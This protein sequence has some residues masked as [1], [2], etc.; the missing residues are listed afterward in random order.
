MTTESLSVTIEGELLTV[1]IGTVAAPAGSGGGSAAWGDITGTLS[2]QTDLSAALALKAPLASPTLTGTPAAPTAAGGTST[3]QIATTAFA[4]GEITTHA[5][6]T[7]PHGDRS[8][9]TSAVSTHAALTTGVH[10]LGGASQLNVGTTAGTVAAGDHAHAGVYQPIA[11][12]LTNTT[13]AFTT[14]QETKLSGIEAAAD[15]TDAGN[16]GTAID[17]ATAKTTPVDADTVPLIDSAAGNVLKKLSWANIKATAKTYFDTLYQAASAT[18]TTWAGITPGTGI[19]TAIGTNV[20]TAGSVVVNGGAL[21]TP[22]SGNLANCTGYPGGSGDVVGPASSTD[23]AVARFD[24]TTGKLLQ[25]TSNVT[26]ADTGA[27]SIAPDANAKALTIASHTQTASN[28]AIDVAQTWNATGV[29]MTG[30]KINITDTASSASSIIWDGQVGGNSRAR[31][32]KDGEVSVSATDQSTTYAKL[33]SGTHGAYVQV[34]LVNGNVSRIHSDTS[35]KW[36]FD[37][38]ST[39]AG[40]FIDA[41]NG[42]R[43]GSGSY[44]GFG[45]GTNTYSATAD[46]RLFRDA[47]N[48]LALRRTTNAQTLIV[49][50]TYTDASNLVQAELAATSTAVTLSAVTAGTG[51]DNVP[52]TI[53]AAGT[54]PVA[55]GSPLAL[56]SYTVAGVPSA[57]AAGAGAMIYVSNE[58]G[59]AIPAFSDGTDWRRVTD[60]AVVS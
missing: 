42:I 2:A 39:G 20:G 15:V 37:D 40:L 24:S 13:A 32:M 18:L 29:V 46:V 43:V 35:G 53:T 7:D 34:K 50:G 54:S 26:I 16:V 1:E 11:T 5:G 59:G 22:S 60:R 3:T 51:A 19:A 47:A 55:I 52:V 6:A 17:G 9:A 27:V 33:V 12:V 41:G 36:L 58:S 25:N 4:A 21:G 10:G 30:W 57:S 28:P 14:A 49:S 23:N 48:R 56:K 44:I 8:F 38:G 31:F 45:D